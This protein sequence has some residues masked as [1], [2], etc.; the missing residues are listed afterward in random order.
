MPTSESRRG[1][2]RAATESKP[3]GLILVF[4]VIGGLSFDGDALCVTVIAL[5]ILG[6]VQQGKRGRRKSSKKLGLIYGL[7]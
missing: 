6:F 5:K 3:W 1:R 4:A 2:I 7:A